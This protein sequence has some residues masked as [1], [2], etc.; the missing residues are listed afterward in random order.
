MSKLIIL[1]KRPGAGSFGVCNRQTRRYAAL[2]WPP[3]CALMMCAGFVR[4][5]LTMRAV[6]AAGLLSPNRKPASAAA[7]DCRALICGGFRYL[8]AGCMYSRGGVTLISTERASGCGEILQRRGWPL[9]RP[10]MCRRTA[11]A[12]CMLS[13]GLKSRATWPKFSEC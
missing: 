5:S 2:P 12:N 7:C 4:H 6:I 11:C 8:P 13:A 9:A 10:A 3:A 1:T